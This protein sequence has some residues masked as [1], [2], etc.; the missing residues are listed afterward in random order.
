MILE[1]HIGV[2]LY[3][4]EGMRAVQSG[5]FALAE[6][7]HLWR[8]LLIHGRLNYLRNAELI[9]YFFYKNMVFT[10]PQFMYAY[11]NGY[12]GQTIYDDYYITCYN[13]VFTALP[14]TAKAIYDQDIN[15]SK[16]LDGPKYRSLLP[17]L[18]YVG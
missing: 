2:G 4:N 14:L 10:L 11:I 1:A 3:G 7:Q 6:F 15:P 17:K 5:D 16:D 13:M 8:L 18:Y 12:S 9:L